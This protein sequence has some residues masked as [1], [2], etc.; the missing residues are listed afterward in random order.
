MFID[1]VAELPDVTPSR[2][3]LY[4][5]ERC[6]ES[7]QVVHATLAAQ[8]GQCDDRAKLPCRRVN[9]ARSGFATYRYRYDDVTIPVSFCLR[10]LQH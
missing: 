3:G 7:T 8:D 10:S 2:G 9:F 6:S 1:T 5:P 4:G